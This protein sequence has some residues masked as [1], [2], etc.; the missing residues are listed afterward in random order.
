MGDFRI[1]Q[2]LVSKRESPS[3]SSNCSYNVL[4]IQEKYTISN[5]IPDQIILL[6]YFTKCSKE[7]GYILVVYYY[8]A[9]QKKTLRIA[10]VNRWFT[11]ILYISK[12]CLCPQMQH[13]SFASLVLFQ[14][15]L[16]HSYKEEHFAVFSPKK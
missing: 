7:N 6:F 10:K 16:L 1:K 15:T 14:P 9:L 13:K 8:I 4:R 2:L 5:H 11:H 12:Q 3:I